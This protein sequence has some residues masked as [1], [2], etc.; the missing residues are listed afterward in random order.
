[1][2]VKTKALNKYFGTDGI[3]GNADTLL[4]DHLCYKIGRF[5]GHYNNKQN[6]IIIGRD[7]RISGSRIVKA[8]ASGLTRSGANIKY[9]D[10]TS[11]PSVCYALAS[12]LDFDFGIMISAS[13][14]P[15]QDNG[16]KIFK[17]SGIKIDEELEAEIE[18]YI[19]NND[20]TSEIVD[21]NLSVDETLIN[22][23]LNYLASKY[24]YDRKYKILIDCANGSTSLLAKRLFKDKLNQEVTIINDKFDGKNIN[25]E[26]GSTHIECIQ[27]YIKENDYD[28]GF[29]FD[30]D[31]D[32]LIAIDRY[33]NVC[34]GDYQIYLGAKYLKEIKQLNNNK[35]VVTSMTNL[36]TLDDL[37]KIDIGYE[38]VDVGDKYVYQCLDKYN[39]SVGGEQSGHI[40][41]R[42]DLNTGDGMLSAIQLLNIMSYF[43]YDLA[44]L[45]KDLQTFPQVLINLEVNDKDKIMQE[46][47]SN[48]DIKNLYKSLSKK[49]L[50]SIRK[51]GTEPLIRLMCQAP[52]IERCNEVINKAVNIIKSID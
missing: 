19:D 10:I 27:K 25:F 41:Y 40:I 15:Y 2:K 33:G 52:N 24:K 21:I 13:H 37:S 50:L 16:I 17:K 30:G 1:M 32:R 26:C 51:S 49:E 47:E 38:I 46:I 45:I 9:L 20:I 7:T 35:V 48:L 11:T 8:L 28:I 36:G 43:N 22:D 12:N 44:N 42:N 34:N 4:D 6:T 5:L 39:L 3:R 18:D 14:N 29:S 31:G 23:Y